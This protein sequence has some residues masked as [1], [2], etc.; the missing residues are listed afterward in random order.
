MIQYQEADHPMS[1]ERSRVTFD[2]H[3]ADVVDR[4]HPARPRIGLR[5]G[6]GERKQLLIAGDLLLINSSLLAAVTIWNRFAPSVPALV[7]SAKWFIT[8]SL[9]WLVFAALLDVYNLARAASVS[10]IIASISITWILTVLTYVFIPV[11]TPRAWRAQLRI[12]PRDQRRHR[13]P[14]LACLL[15]QGPLPTRIPAPCDSSSEW[16]TQLASSRVS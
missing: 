1:D 4:Q 13:D 10:S 11:L 5:L 7:A 2:A 3:A 8:L 15:C 16:G 12:R 9:V 6:A 14:G